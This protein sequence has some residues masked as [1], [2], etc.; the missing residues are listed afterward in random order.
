MKIH[1]RFENIRRWTTFCWGASLNKLT[2][3]LTILY[4]YSGWTVRQLMPNGNL[5]HNSFLQLNF[6]ITT[7]KNYFP[8]FLGI[9]HWRDICQTKSV[10]PRNWCLH[11]G[12]NL[13]HYIS[14]IWKANSSPQIWLISRERRSDLV[15]CFP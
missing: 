13:I 8:F 7:K 11:G 14:L 10:S 1:R 2:E 4:C 9:F 6:L 12:L 3:E 5:L 15:I